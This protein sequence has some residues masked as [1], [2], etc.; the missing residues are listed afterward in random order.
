MGGGGISN[1]LLKAL[2]ESS[3]SENLC[4]SEY[5]PSWIW[6]NNGVAAVGRQGKLADKTG[7]HEQLA[8]G[9]LIDK[10]G[11]QWYFLSIF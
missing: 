7:R 8:D 5:K 10:I 1:A 3:V 6:L 4:T 2:L 11:R 9:Q